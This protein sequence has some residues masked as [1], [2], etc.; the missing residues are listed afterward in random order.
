[1]LGKFIIIDGT[2][3]AGKGTQTELLTK[4]LKELGHQV[5]KADFPQYGQKSAGL[6][7]EYLNGK[8][9]PQ[10]EVGPYR[11]SIFFAVDRYDASF[12][13]RKWL[14]EGKVVISNR[15]VTANMGHQGGAI[16]DDQERRKYFDWLYKLEFET[17]GIPRPDL[18]I[19]LHV[20]AET[21][22]ILVDKKGHRDYVGGQK[23]DIHEAD[24]G[25]LQRAEKTYLQ[26]AQSFPGFVL[27][28]CAPGGQLLSI[29]E[30]HKLI[31][32]KVEPKLIAFGH[33]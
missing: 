11:A 33:F 28:E 29:E 19:I 6:V 22:Q 23:R 12:K 15:Y 5:E 3:G 30:V 21:A 17:F 16:P 8:Y 27:V 4:K 26:I 18:N 7:E 24:L 13:I 32:E 2:D 25:H 14:E 1:M 20:P 9:G 31:W 10:S